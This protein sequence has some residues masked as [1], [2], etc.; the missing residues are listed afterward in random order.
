[1]PYDFLPFKRFCFHTIQQSVHVLVKAREFKI[2]DDHE[3]NDNYDHKNAD[4]DDE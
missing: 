1:M 4:D 3:M 2:N